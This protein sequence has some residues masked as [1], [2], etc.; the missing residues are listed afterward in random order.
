VR[1]LFLRPNNFF[2]NL[3]LTL[4]AIDFFNILLVIYFFIK[5]F[6]LG[7]YGI[8]GSVVGL[9]FIGWSI[10]R[11]PMTMC[12]YNFCGQISFFLQHFIYFE[13]PNLLIHHLDK[14]FGTSG[15]W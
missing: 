12:V 10:T 15:L 7:S 9:R 1:I 3:F 5:V 4:W 8:V 6:Y 13:L 14:I 11:W 2:P